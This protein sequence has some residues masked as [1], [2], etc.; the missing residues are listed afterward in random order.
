MHSVRD[1][2]RLAAQSLRDDFDEMTLGR[3]SAPLSSS[4][5]LIGN[6]ADLFIEAGAWVEGASLNTEGGP[7]YIGKD[8]VVMEGSLIRGGLG[9]CNNAQVKMGAKLYGAITIGPW[10][11]VGGEVGNSVFQGFS[12][13]G[14]DG[15]VG[16]S[17]IG[18]WCN[19]GADTNTS[20][21]KNNYSEVKVWSY[22]D[23]QL[24]PSGLNFCGV[25]MGDHSKCA[26]NT[27]LNTGTTVGVNAN[28]F[29]Y[30]FP[31]KFVPSWSWGGFKQEEHH[32]LERSLETAERVMSRRKVK[33]TPAERRLLE[34]L[35]DQTA[36]LR[37]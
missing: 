37:G 8:A 30:G 7:I 17:V 35:F 27:Q 1:L 12:N 11:K 19:L 4:N 25:V 22:R 33:L 31:P 6:P 5:R 23:K 9:L 26:I 3:T 34:A 2:F 18:A 29:G 13:K 15:F 24:I 16:N 21:L 14:H 32:D 10:C 36:D 20:N 28:I